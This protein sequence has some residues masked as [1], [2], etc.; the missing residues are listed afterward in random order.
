MRPIVA[1][2]V[3]ALLVGHV[4]AQAPTVMREQ[5]PPAR[6][7]GRVVAAATGRPL[8]L[9]TVTLGG[10]NPYARRSIRTDSNGN[11]EF[12]S[13]PAGRYSLVAIRKGYLE[14]NFDQ[15][16]PFAR[17]RLLELAEGEQLDGMDFRL[18][19]GAVITGVITDDDGRPIAGRLG[20][21]DARAVRP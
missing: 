9:A 16:S 2:L 20:A 15:P 11:Y 8:M 7:R 13:L 4:H 19:R 6:I 14:Q 5:K 18:H 21:C 10:G 1:S 3:V 12:A 17:Y